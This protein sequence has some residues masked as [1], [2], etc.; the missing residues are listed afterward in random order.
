M[1]ASRLRVDQP[2]RYRIQVQGRLDQQWSERLSG[3]EITH[4]I[5]SLELPV[6]TL[7]GQLPDQAALLGVLTALYDIRMPVLSV[8]CL[9]C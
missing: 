9:S 7:L 2:A 1:G 6:T 3:L 4:E 8:E 5:G